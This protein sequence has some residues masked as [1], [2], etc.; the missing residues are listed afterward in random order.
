MYYCTFMD[1]LVVSIGNSIGLLKV[2]MKYP[3]KIKVFAF[4]SNISTMSVSVLIPVPVIG[5]ST[6][7]LS[8]MHGVYLT[9]PAAGDIRPGIRI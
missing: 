8:L 4:I 5:P 9:L 6:D 3:F 7:M 2:Y 1:Y